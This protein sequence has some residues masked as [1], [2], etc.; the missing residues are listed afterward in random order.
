MDA[1]LDTVT[2]RELR[3]PL[4]LTA[5]FQEEND[6]HG[7]RRSPPPPLGGGHA[8]RRARRRRPGVSERQHA[9]HAGAGP[10]RGPPGHRDRLH[11]P[12][13]RAPAHAYPQ[14]RLPAQDDYFAGYGSDGLALWESGTPTA[15]LTVG[16]ALHAHRVRAKP[17]PGPAVD[18][19]VVRALVSARC[20]RL[21]IVRWP[22]LAA[23]HRPVDHPGSL[24]EPLRAR[25]LVGCMRS[26]LMSNV[27]HTVAN[28]HDVVAGPLVPSRGVIAPPR[29][30]GESR[31]FAWNV[32]QLLA[33]DP[34]ED[35]SADCAQASRRGMRAAGAHRCHV[36]LGGHDEVDDGT[37]LHQVA[38]LRSRWVGIAF[39]IACLRSIHNE[40]ARD[41]RN[42]IE[43]PL[44]APV[45]Q[46][47]TALARARVRTD[48]TTIQI[49]TTINR[50]IEARR[51]TQD[52]AAPHA[53]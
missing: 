43:G 9:T 47:A 38:T 5:T 44:A 10:G 35:S 6:L 19:R 2:R 36:R 4:W 50:R 30:T 17:T 42:D 14:R 8:R 24:V 31:P 46:A 3:V 41:A 16:R 12:T 37:A 28:S 15:L 49:R 26:S 11:R 48:E 51:Q 20:R 23:L 18:G 7:A 25:D 27:A 33:P 21:R 52:S 13:D 53:A 29:A 39:L 32:E 45:Q 1:L 22:R 34:A 40:T